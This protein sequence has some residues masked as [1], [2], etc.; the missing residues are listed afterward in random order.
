M[1][2]DYSH[3]TF[4]AFVVGGDCALTSNGWAFGFS[5]GAPCTYYTR[6]L[7]AVRFAS[8]AG[9]VFTPAAIS[10]MATH[11]DEPRWAAKYEA[12]KA[13]DHKRTQAKLQQYY[14]KQEKLV[15]SARAKLTEEEFAAVLEEGRD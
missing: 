14:R 15:A 10:A 6:S 4:S 13:R 7:A 11:K 3:G 8:G 2:C 5:S 1:V 9:Y 12:K